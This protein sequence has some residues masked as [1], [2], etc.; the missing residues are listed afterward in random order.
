MLLKTAKK[1]KRLGK[2]GE[3]GTKEWQKSR[4]EWRWVEVKEGQRKQQK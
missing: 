1:G 2:K 3:K 4:E